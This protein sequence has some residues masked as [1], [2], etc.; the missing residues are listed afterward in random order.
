LSETLATIEQAIWRE[1]RQCVN[2]REHPWRTPVLA[3]VDAD[4]ADARVVVLREVNDL[5]LV[6]FTDARSP[7]VT[8]LRRRPQATLLFWSPALRW[9]LRVRAVVDVDTRRALPKEANAADYLAALAPGSRLEAAAVQGHEPH[10]ALVTADVRSIDWLE[11]GP[12]GAHRRAAFATGDP[13]CWLQ[14]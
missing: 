10:F 14:P 3:T 4:A 11:L 5:A 6:F 9:Q 13:A 1:L 7:K 8:Q 2:D 12:S